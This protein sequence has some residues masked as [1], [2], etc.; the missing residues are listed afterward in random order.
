MFSNSRRDS[1]GGGGS[2]GNFFGISGTGPHSVGV[3]TEIFSYLQLH[4]YPTSSD[5]PGYRDTHFWLDTAKIRIFA[6]K[7]I[8]PIYQ[9]P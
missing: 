5:L 4:F 6:A 7:K 3:V 1:V 2:T 9:I 8:I